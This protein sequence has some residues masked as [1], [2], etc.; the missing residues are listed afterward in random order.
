MIPIDEAYHEALRDQYESLRRQMESQ[1][2]VRWDVYGRSGYLDKNGDFHCYEEEK[3]LIEKLKNFN[4]VA[5][6]VEEAVELYAFGTTVVAAYDKLQLKSPDWIAEKLKEV[7]VEVK[8]RAR[9]EKVARLKAARARLDSLKSVDDR[10]KD[11]TA[12]IADL[13]KELA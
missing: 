12:E 10:R 5:N 7:D 2:P 8:R 1:T 4:V 3:M 13:E 11:L 9:D 6:P